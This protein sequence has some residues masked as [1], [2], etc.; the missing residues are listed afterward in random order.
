[1]KAMLFK[2]ALPADSLLFK[3]IIIMTDLVETRG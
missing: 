2:S 3:Q 1:M